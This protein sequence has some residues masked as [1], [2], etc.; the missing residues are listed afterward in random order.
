MALA[1][2]ICGLVL[3]G[4]F[5]LGMNSASAWRPPAGR[6]AGADPGRARQRPRLGGRQ[7]AARPGRA[8]ARAT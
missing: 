8:Q 1:K 2:F 4:V 6:S 5:S 3:A 7:M